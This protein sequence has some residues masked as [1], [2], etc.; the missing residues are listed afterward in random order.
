LENSFFAG[1]KSSD[2]SATDGIKVN[3]IGSFILD[4]TNQ[5]P[6]LDSSGERGCQLNYRGK[7]EIR[8]CEFGVLRQ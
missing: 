1:L 6:R 2:I 7:V 5:Q 3:D 8:G 4:V